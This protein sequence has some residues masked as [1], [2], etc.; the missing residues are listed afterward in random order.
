MHVVALDEIKFAL[1]TY[2]EQDCVIASVAISGTLHPQIIS[3]SS[4]PSK[5]SKGN[6]LDTNYGYQPMSTTVRK[7]GTRSQ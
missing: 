5:T 3:T 7:H 2:S 1:A 4:V 6:A